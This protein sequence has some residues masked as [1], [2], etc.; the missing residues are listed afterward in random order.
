MSFQSNTY[1]TRRF[2]IRP[3]AQKWGVE[4]HATEAD[5]R[6]FGKRIGVLEKRI[7]KLLQP[8]LEKQP[9]VEA[10]L[11]RSFLDAPT[12]RAYL[13]HYQTRRNRVKE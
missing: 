1:L 5:F 9:Q 10:M 3:D 7:E 13:L 8:F 2:E 12:K 4:G 6:E 11:E